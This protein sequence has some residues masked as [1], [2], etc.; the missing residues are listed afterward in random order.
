VRP[1]LDGPTLVLRIVSAKMPK[2]MPS[3]PKGLRPCR[4]LLPI[5][6]SAPVFDHDS[7]ANF[8]KNND[9]SHELPYRRFR[10][11]AKSKAAAAMTKS[12]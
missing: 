8:R 3:D 10:L 12:R 9:R 6:Q 2:L 4:L 7:T 1:N 5:I 11:I